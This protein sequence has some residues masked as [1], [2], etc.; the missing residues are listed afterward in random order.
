MGRWSIMSAKKDK[1]D[2]WQSTWRGQNK[3]MKLFNSVNSRLAALALSGAVLA[4]SA[5]AFTQKPKAESS[6]GPIN[7]QVDERPIA[8]ELGGHTSFAPVIKKVA[9][10]VVKVSTSTKI[11]NTAF[12]GPPGMEDLMRRFFGD[13]SQGRAPRRNF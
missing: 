4:G 6:R 2:H 9:P 5:L 13:E 10:G 3:F 8:R 12:S 11:H 1:I 7:V